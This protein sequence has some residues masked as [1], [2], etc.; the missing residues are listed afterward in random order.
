MCNE[1]IYPSRKA[2]KKNRSEEKCKQ[3]LLV[4]NMYF[5]DVF[6]GQSVHFLKASPSL[7]L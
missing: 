4:Y 7:T 5:D 1:E 2:K 3:Y 6:G